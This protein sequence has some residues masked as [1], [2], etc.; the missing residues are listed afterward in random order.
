MRYALGSLTL[1]VYFLQVSLATG[2]GALLHYVHL[3]SETTITSIMYIVTTGVATFFAL[4]LFLTLVFNFQQKITTSTK[5]WN[6]FVSYAR[7]QI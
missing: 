7:Q 5:N 6:I 1:V 4:I 3:V 2:F